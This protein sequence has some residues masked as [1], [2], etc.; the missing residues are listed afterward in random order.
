MSTAPQLAVQSREFRTSARL[1]ASESASFTLFACALFVVLG[2]VTTLL[3]PILPLVSARWS[4]SAAEAGT[5]FF[6]QFI[7]STF[8]TL[9]SGAVLAKRGF[10]LAVL[11]G[12]AL[13]I[14]GVAALVTAN[15]TLGRYAVACYGLGLGI[16]LPAINLAVAEANRNRRAASV[17]LL[18]FA[19]GIG[20]ISGP[21]L[22][23]ALHS[24]NRFLSVLSV[25]LAFGLIISMVST[26]PAKAERVSD[27]R[28]EVK[29]NKRLWLLVPL[30]ASS[31]FLFC[32][33]ENA[34]GGWASSLALPSFSSAFTATSASIA[35]WTFFLAGRAL[36]PTALRYLPEAKLLLVAI[37]SAASGVL[38]FY[39]ATNAA[40]IL[41]AC[42]L[43]GFG[44]GPGFPLLIARVSE[45]IGAQHPACAFCFAFAG[46][47]AA[48]LP[49]LVGLVGAKLAQ[50]RAGLLLPLVGLLLLVPISGALPYPQPAVK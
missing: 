3:G 28:T 18:N 29:D 7:S 19:W 50:P 49:T 12:V 36:A 41:L 25:L 35:F 30:I 47:G 44:I 45:L 43:A 42:A 24:L 40:T 6:W 16:S 4:I 9:L 1:S 23:S 34:I 22:L 13:C 15:W 48:T 2:V 39:F 46:V 33:V 26:M 31:M 37:I 11:L 10:K 8:G 27:S 14:V 17:S 5:L 38:A 20:A 21:V 32:G